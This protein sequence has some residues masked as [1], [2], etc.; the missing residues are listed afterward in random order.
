MSALL[1]ARGLRKS[2]LWRRRWGR[3]QR[4]Q[5][6]AG[7]DLEAE[8]GECL[9]LVGESGSGK[10][11]LGRCLLRLVEPDRGEIRFDGEDLIAL[12]PREL[13]RRRTRFQMVFQDSLGAFDPRMKVGSSIAEPIRIHHLLPAGEI[14]SRVSSLLETVGLGCDFA[15]RY[16]HQISGGQRQRVG[17]ARALATEPQLLVLDEPV[18]ALDVSVRARILR[19]LAGLRRKLALTM[20]LIAHDLAMVEQIADRVA[21]MY[22]GRIIEIGTARAILQRPQHPYTASLLAAVPKP[23][24]NRR[25][26]RQAIQGEIPSPLEPP[27]GCAFH[28][29]CPA[30]RNADASLRRPC[31]EVVPELSS[32]TAERAAACHFPGGSS[33]AE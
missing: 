17:I 18:S 7:I 1:E 19:L 16:P 31:V 28:P 5:A 10:T 22:L 21:V 30:A 25:G 29:R 20:I 15:D 27:S 9:A 32:P 14:P 11:T 2:F 23:D 26:R 33:R 8:R 3:R 13:R 12:S 6:I 24:P 4:L